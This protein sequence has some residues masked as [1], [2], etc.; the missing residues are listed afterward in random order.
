[1]AQRSSDGN[2][3][4]L[5]VKEGLADFSSNDYLGL[6]GNV[7]LA[8]MIDET[9]ASLSRLNGA[10][11]SRLLTGNSSLAM[12]LEGKLS[13]IFR[14]P[15]ALLFNSGYAA[16][17]A[18]LAT[19]P[20]RGDTIVFDQAI[21]A[22]IKEGARLSTARHY[23][24]RHND[25]RDLEKKLHL[26]SGKVFV[27]VESLYSMEGDWAPIDH[28]L[29]VCQKYEASLII[30][31]AHTTGWYGPLGAGWICQRGL[32]NGFMARVYTFGKAVGLHGACVVGD[33][34]LIDYL[35]NFA[36]PFIY[37]TALPQHSIISI[38]CAWDYIKKNPQHSTQL[39]KNISLYLKHMKGV[40]NLNLLN[41]GS[42]LQWL[43]MPGNLEAREF[44]SYLQSQG[45]DL[46]PIL[47]PTVQ[48]GRERLRICLHAFN[49]PEQ[50][51]RL[52]EVINDRVR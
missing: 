21:H 46:R 16:N 10:T 12:E 22:C 23:S 45:F 4:S 33:Q 30:D 29:S 2:L 31:E 38:G 44:S 52:T 3:R 48:T 25:V 40:P 39:N 43:S 28:L 35:V 5:Q 27:V 34:L 24:F 50:I 49:T 17:M 32:E 7:E 14:A 37:T 26:A 1:M 9:S 13:T 15:A 19:I 36:R 51:I 20:Q 18:L 11:G 47:S 8:K 6:A 42:P 41:E